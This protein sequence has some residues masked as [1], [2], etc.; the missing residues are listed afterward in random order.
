MATI[1]NAKLNGA[2][3]LKAL[4]QTGT[5]DSKLALPRQVLGFTARKEKRIATANEIVDVMEK[6]GVMAPFADHPRTPDLTLRKALA[7]ATTGKW[8]G[9]TEVAELPIEEILL[10]GQQLPDEP[11]KPAA[12]EA[13]ESLDA[14]KS[15]NRFDPAGEHRLEE[16]LA[17]KP[18]AKPK[19]VAKV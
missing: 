18:V 7:L 13:V 19:P 5:S 16:S 1:E 14:G 11:K 6:A 9:P 17:I 4:A 2:E 10:A 15:V 8:D 3:L 12:E